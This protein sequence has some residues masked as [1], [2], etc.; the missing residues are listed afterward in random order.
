MR[1][2]PVTT[3]NETMIILDK[4]GRKLG[5]CVH[6]PMHNGW[7]FIPATT[8]RKSSRKFWPTATTCIPKWAFDL[9]DEMLTSSEFSANTKAA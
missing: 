2:A 5:A 8:S 1:T 6:Y 7:Q 4:L 3:K 9:S